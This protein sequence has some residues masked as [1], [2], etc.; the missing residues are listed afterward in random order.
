MGA[1]GTLE[2]ARVNWRVFGARG[3]AWTLRDRLHSRRTRT[4]LESCLHAILCRK[5]RIV[6]IQIGAN[7]GNRNDPLFH[8][9]REVNADARSEPRCS[10]ILVEPVRHLFDQLKINYRGCPGVAFENVAVSDCA[11]TRNFYHIDPS[12]DITGS[13]MPHWLSQIG[14]LVPERLEKEFAR[15]EKELARQGRGRNLGDFIANH[16]ISEEVTCV[17][18]GDLLDRHAVE[19]LDLLQ[20][21][22][23]GY[24]YEIVRSID[25]ERVKPRMIN[26]ERIHLQEDE[27]RCRHLL[28]E[29]GYKLF[30][31]Y[32]MDT[33]AVLKPARLFARAS[34]PPSRS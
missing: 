31:R 5:Q 4:E 26:Y 14:S 3:V 22:A 17:T 34:P 11:G 29:Q 18:L 28:E 30:D 2:R 13:D 1:D 27:A 10:A 32:R 25:F 33:L 9:I 19:E 8:F 23:E 24:D 12:V 16:R 7:V 6:V 15:V 21:D 20:I